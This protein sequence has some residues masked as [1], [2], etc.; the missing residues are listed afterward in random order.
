MMRSE[1]PPPALSS[2]DTHNG[3]KL[4][5]IQNI[6]RDTTEPLPYTPDIPRRHQTEIGHTSAEPR[7]KLTRACQC[8]GGTEHTQTRA[9]ARAHSCA[10]STAHTAPPIGSPT[11]S[12]CLHP[13]PLTPPSA[14][15][16]FIAVTASKLTL[17]PRPIGAAASYRCPFC[18]TPRSRSSCL[19]HSLALHLAFSRAHRLRPRVTR[20]HATGAPPADPHAS[21]PRL[22]MCCC[23]F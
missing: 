7:P 5:R 17:S 15:S 20:A 18:V 10:H 12:V 11:C 8:A 16:V 22:A 2:R 19:L 23:S 4:P 14:R 9:R 1:H 13:N 3:C 6:A 21:Q